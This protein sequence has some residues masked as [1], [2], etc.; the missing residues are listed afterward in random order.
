MELKDSG[1]REEFITGAVRDITKGKGRLDLCPLDIIGNILNDTI[2]IN[3]DK[4]IR[5]GV[6][7][8]LVDALNHFIEEV[9]TCGWYGAILEVAKHYEDGCQK[10]GDR[11][12]EMGIPLHCYINSAL[13]HYIMHQQ[14]NTE[15]PHDRA[16][17]WNILGALWTHKHKPEMI[18]LPFREVEA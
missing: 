17:M 16:F 9:L 1:E 7:A 13:R 18:D 2:L 5:T 8:Y 6:E 3:I 15:E 11:N 14:G 12:W 10:Y 4:Y